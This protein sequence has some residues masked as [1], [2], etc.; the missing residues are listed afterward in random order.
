[1]SYSNKTVIQILLISG[2]AILA[3]NDLNGW[4]WLILILFCTLDDKKDKD[5]DKLN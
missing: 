3:S 5:D 4:G 2:I 1:M